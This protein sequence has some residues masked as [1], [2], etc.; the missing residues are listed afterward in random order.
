MY[1]PTR[2]NT[3]NLTQG[4]MDKIWEK[5]EKVGTVVMDPETKWFWDKDMRAHALAI[6]QLSEEGRASLEGPTDFGMDEEVKV[7]QYND[8]LFYN[9]HICTF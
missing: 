5:T 4:E 2:G 1:T 8:T 6:D 3:L 7:L 9:L